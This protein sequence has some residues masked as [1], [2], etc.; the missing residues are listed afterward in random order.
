MAKI[1]LNINGIEVTAFKGQTIL[2]VAKANDIEIPTLCYNEIIEVHGS[3]G[4]C[5]VEVEG[6][7]KLLRACATQAADG[8]VVKTHTDK[9]KSSR[10]I[11]L[12]LLL[13]DHIGDCRAP[14]VLACPAHTDCQGYVGLIANGEYRESL[15]LIK[16]E[17]PLPASI[18]RV[19]PHPC[20]TAC[21]RELLE[22]PV[23]IAWLKSF[24]A[25]I[26]LKGA[27]TF[28]PDLKPSTGKKVAIIGGGP[29]GLT[30]AYFL[31]VEGHKAVIYESMPEMGGM[32]RYG[33]PEYRLPEEVLAAE[34]RTIEKM[35]VEMRNNIKIGKDVELAYL[36]ENYDAVYVGIGAWKS[37]GLRCEGEDLEGVIGGIDFLREF[38]LGKPVK[39][40][41]RIAVVGGG[42]TAMDA[43]RTAIRLGAKEVINLYRR[44]KAEMPAEDIEILE[45]EEEGVK[46]QFLVSPIEV[47]GE[48]GKVSKIRLQKMELGEEDER[49]RRRPVPIEGE[50]ETIEVDSVIVAIGQDVD[51]TGLEDLSLTKW[52]T[53][54]ADENTFT[55]NLPGVFAGGDGIN[56][57]P[58][59]A[60]EA[61]GHAKKAA[62][63]IDSYLQGEIIPHKPL[64]HVTRDDVTAEYFSDRP[65]EHRPEMAHIE[66]SVR[67]G[68]FDEIVGGYTEEQA[69]QEAMRCLECGC[70]DIFEC[71]LFSYSNEYGVEPERLAGEIHHR[72]CDDG[73]PFIIRDSD[74][75]ILCGQCVRVC[76]EVIGSTAL[77]LLDRGFDTVVK[78]A[79]DKALQDTDCI[80]CGQCVT[81][82]P[83][84]AL[85]ERMM[86]PKSQTIDPIVTTTTCSYCSV[87]CSI[88]LTTKGNMVVRSLPNKE[89]AVNDSLLCVKGRF[90]FDLNQLGT[91]LTKP[92]IRKDGE[93]QEVSW[94]EAL[95]YTSKKAQSVGALHGNDS[96]ALSI[97][98]RYTNEEI[99]LISKF[100]R[101]LLKTDNIASFNASRSGLKDVL[102]YDASTNTFEELGLADTIILVG[103]NIMRHHP[104]AGF[105]IK[106][107]TEAGA[108]LVVVN[109]EETRIDEYASVKVT[110]SNDLGFLKEIL[111]AL[112]ESGK[113]PNTDTSQGFEELKASL[114][115]VKVSA[116]AANIAEIYGNSKKAMIVFEQKSITPDAAALIANI[117]VVSGNIARARNGIIQLKQNNNSQGLTDMGV[118]LLGEDIVKGIEDKNIKAL[119]V[120]GEDIPNVNV[121]NLEL[122]VVQDTHLTETA[123][124]ADVVLPGVGFAETSGTYTNSERRIQKLNQAVEPLVEYENW[125]VVLKLA[126]VLTKHFNYSSLD[127]VLEEIEKS[128]PEYLGIRKTEFEDIFWPVNGS[129][130]LYG[131]GF[132]FPDKK[133]KL[134][135][136]EDGP[137]FTEITNTNN[138]TNTFVEYLVK[139]GLFR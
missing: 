43:C 123:K 2:E 134:K 107:A 77:G 101:D 6:T 34:I 22:E 66:P 76:D 24:V 112:I 29:S 102:G 130:V 136:V 42:N 86:I 51:S 90:A 56:N 67:R 69:Q 121:D 17:L 133:A 20:E 81:V 100:G 60:I 87:G 48:D 50:E 45:A 10:K 116:E 94:D 28:M 8:M 65:I 44:T 57:G 110:P 1:R 83:T 9:T 118:S 125:Q 129:R 54:I 93:L 98:D 74:K 11:A 61:I 131:Q 124:K 41:D 88:D 119:L 80:S 13:S 92:L 40:G 47:I 99:H 37:S 122:L 106:K 91:R 109:P 115:N 26:D 135:V 103:S 15:K 132:N 4:L 128:V 64:F 73:H 120:F 78:P 16:E 55:T 32:L 138:L 46:F 137:L 85:Q 82:C 68:N 97:S 117:A 84:G 127:E 36:R 38:T 75:C 111:K 63:V 53:I 105:K 89:S 25:D 58:G 35:G 114:A 104:I 33:I 7:P 27:D 30:A 139:E 5:V 95:L 113:A 96:L 12:E 62:L 21:R 49:G 71:K 14:C 3:C 79:F 59:I 19:C 108:K 39:T 126:D 52:G 70:H 23:S 31:A 72:Q 18:G